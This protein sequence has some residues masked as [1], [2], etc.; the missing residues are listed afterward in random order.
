MEVGWGGGGL[1]GG[2]GGRWVW[3]VV[4]GVGVRGCRVG[5]GRWW[6]GG[7]CRCNFRGVG[8]NECVC[9]CVFLYSLEKFWK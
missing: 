3:V 8:E 4:G 1:G 7:G 6:C 5:W 9:V 2:R